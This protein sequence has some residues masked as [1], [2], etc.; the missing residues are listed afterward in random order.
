MKNGEYVESAN[1]RKKDKLSVELPRTSKD[2]RRL[3][4]WVC[5]VK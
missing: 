3:E 1:D 4:I 2:E 5:L